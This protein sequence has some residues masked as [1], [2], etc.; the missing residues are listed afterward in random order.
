MGTR[1]LMFTAL[2]LVSI[3]TVAVGQA[4]VANPLKPNIIL[5]V[6]DDHGMD[7]MRYA[8]MY[9]DGADQWLIS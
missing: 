3:N 8:V 9:A 5:F 4:P 2:L 6:S 7:A 1:T